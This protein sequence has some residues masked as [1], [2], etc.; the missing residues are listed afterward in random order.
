MNI[1]QKREI[2]SAVMRNIHP[3]TLNLPVFENQIAAI[4]LCK[5][6]VMPSHEELDAG[7]IIKSRGG[8]TIAPHQS[9]NIDA[10]TYPLYFPRGEQTFVKDAL[11]KNRSRKRAR[12]IARDCCNERYVEGVYTDAGLDDAHDLN[13][14]DDEIT[15][16]NKQARKSRFI[17]RREFV[18]YI[19]ARRPDF[20]KHRII[21]TGKLYAQYVLHSFARIEADRL[22]AIGKHLTEVRSTTASALFKYLDEKLNEKGVKL[23]KLVNMPQTYVGSRKWYQKLYSDAMAVSLKLGK[24]DLF[25]TFTGNQEWPE[26]KNNLVSK[27]DSWITDPFLCCR[28]FF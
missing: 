28:V 18:V 27:F 22:C 5:D 11:P 17:S 3:G 16:G 25:I 19:L 2:P 12:E 4:Y 10:L 20:G 15:L 8:K 21:G 7:L 6:G 26:I 14:D 24:P 1:K 9:Y 13:D 23:G